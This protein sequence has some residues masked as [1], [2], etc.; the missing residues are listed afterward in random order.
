M[1]D[2]NGEENTEN[3]REVLEY[4]R[5]KDKE[6]CSEIIEKHE[7]FIRANCRKY[8]LPGQ[9]E[10]DLLQE[11]RI[12]FFKAIRDY[13]P[14]R[15]PVFLAFAVRCVKGQCISALKGAQR[16]KQRMTYAAKS[17]NAPVFE[18][19]PSLLAIDLV[20]DEKSNPE[21]DGTNWDCYRV[22]DELLRMN[23]SPNEYDVLNL[24]L[25]GYTYQDVAML[26][27]RTRKSIDNTLQRVRRKLV[28]LDTTLPGFQ[29]Q[30]I[31]FLRE[32]ERRE[33]AEGR[34]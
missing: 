27:N 9:E 34:I 14:E 4:Q 19:N 5:T 3:V 28:T 25:N 1:I 24:W 6:L 23:L 32:K 8:F 10:D 2:P 33:V 13:D 15:H 16:M 30:F 17:L 29:M 12:G 7:L 22:C 11:A 31:G 21:R 20:I 26:M 18:Y